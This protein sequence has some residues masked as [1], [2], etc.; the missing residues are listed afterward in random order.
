[1]KRISTLKSL[2]F[3][4]VLLFTI[5]SCKKDKPSQQ[6][7]VV[8]AMPTT[9]GLIETDSSI[10][11]LLL[12]AISKVGTQ[13]VNYDLVFD[14]GSG[15]MVMDASG[16][17][18]SSMITSSGFNFSGDSTIVNGITITSQ[19]SNIEYGA[20]S[21]TTDTVYG[22]LA[23][24][25][26]TVGDQNGNIIIKRLPFFL[27]YKAVNTNGNVYPPHDFDVFGATEEYDVTFPNNSYISSPFS[28]FD[29]GTGLTKGFKIAP[30]GTNYFSY[31]G[32]YAPGVITLGL[33]S[34]DLSSASG[35]T[36]SQLY[37]YAG[38][39]YP[40][41]IPASI[42][43]NSKN[44]TTN[45]IF[46]SGTEPYTYLEDPSFSGS[47]TLLPQNSNVAVS[48]NSGFNYNY[49]ISPTDNLTVV[50]NPNTSGGI[51]SIISLEY[52]LNNEY[53][54]DLT[55]HRLGLKTN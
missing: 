52:F 54:L 2:L 6:S 33:T 35:F 32:G 36:M 40:P 10:Y 5:A 26:V 4:S 37:Y 17:V 45:V 39:G 30:L 21:A 1:M 15:G 55:N 42:T 13:N 38:I 34:A 50:E 27:Y 9:L 29:P 12:I 16:I 18:P 53:M 31:I 20:D 48:T 46:D 43:Y 14:T 11:K 49:T 23:Y 25:P 19:T 22:N 51:I 3:I 24:P 47:T 8:N 7:A 41:I 28:Y 44:F